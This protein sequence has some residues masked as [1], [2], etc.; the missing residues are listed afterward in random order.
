M[1]SKKDGQR[2]ETSSDF[3]SPLWEECSV[4]NRVGRGKLRTVKTH[5]TKDLQRD[6]TISR[7]TEIVINGYNREYLSF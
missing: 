1:I 2:G 7:A 5:G 3:K 4:E 6:R